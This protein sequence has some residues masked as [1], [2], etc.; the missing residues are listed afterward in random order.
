MKYRFTKE[1]LEKI[2]L[3]SFSVAEVCRK[4]NIKVAGG[5]YKTLIFK[6]KDWKIDTS[7]FRGQG[8]NKNLIFKP[9]PPQKNY[10]K[11]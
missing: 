8:W 6:M 2:V 10:Q 9:N 7:H 1:E 4:M 5:N 3:S 11:F